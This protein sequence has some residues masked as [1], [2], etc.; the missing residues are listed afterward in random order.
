[1]KNFLRL[2]TT[3]LLLTAAACSKT[4]EKKEITPTE[5]AALATQFVALRDTLDGRW[6]QMMASDDEKLFFT[7]RLLQEISYLPTADVATINKLQV[8]NERLKARRYA[9]LTMVS[10]SIDSYDSAQVAI[11]TPLRE[12]VGKYYDPAKHKVMGEL[13]AD[14]QLHD[15]LVVRYRG[16]YD[17]AARAY[18]Q[19]VRTHKADVPAAA[20]AQPVPL[21]SLTGM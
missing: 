18:N 8:A 11:L 20:Q 7:K 3:A 4:A 14:I 5:K 9:Q 2:L 10:D 12:L 17:Q 21:F 13:A 6:A 1:M 16:S 15:D 19:F